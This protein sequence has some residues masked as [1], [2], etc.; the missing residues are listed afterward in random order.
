M[1]NAKP[2]FKLGQ[3]VYLHIHAEEPGMITGILEREGGYVYYVTWAEAPTGEGAHY[4][5]ELTDE[6]SFSSG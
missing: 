5:M 3:T 1:A 2:T 4:P 6:K